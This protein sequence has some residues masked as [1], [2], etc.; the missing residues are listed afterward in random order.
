MAR[1]R[2]YG[3]QGQQMSIRQEQ[4]KPILGSQ[5]LPLGATAIKYME[6][7]Y[8]VETGLKMVSSKP[9]HQEE[10]Q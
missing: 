8:P 9:Y 5:P 3:G 1:E 7:E 10:E 2:E 6:L 4:P